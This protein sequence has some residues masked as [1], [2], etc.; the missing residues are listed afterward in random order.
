M[1]KFVYLIKKSDQPMVLLESLSQFMPAIT[2]VPGPHAP[3]DFAWVFERFLASKSIATTPAMVNWVREHY[4]A[5]LLTAWSL[6]TDQQRAEMNY[7][8]GSEFVGPA[9]ALPDS[10]EK[11]VRPYCS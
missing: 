6:L 9:K 2:Y 8:V 3:G 5:R 4:C 7:S 11:E 10:Y 1:Q